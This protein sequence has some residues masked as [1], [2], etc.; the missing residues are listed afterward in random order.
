MSISVL[1][2]ALAALI[3][4]AAGGALVARALKA[5]RRNT[6]ETAAM[7]NL[8]RQVDQ[9]SRAFNAR[10]DAV[11]G[12]MNRTFAHALQQAT[13]SLTGTIGAVREETRA[14][15]SEKFVQ[16]TERLGDLEATHERIMEFR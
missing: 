5:N 14:A 12:E 13:Q 11:S 8:L 7:D 4:G 15:I 16:V 6:E 9:T 3:L 2:V 10:L 1:F